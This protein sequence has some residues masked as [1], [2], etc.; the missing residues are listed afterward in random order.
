MASSINL[1]D[2]FSID[3]SEAYVSWLYVNIAYVSIA[4][5]FLIIGFINV[6]RICPKR[7]GCKFMC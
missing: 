4:V 2:Y 5:V 7:R 6:T 1:S 3:T